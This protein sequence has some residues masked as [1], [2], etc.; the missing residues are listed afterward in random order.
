MQYHCTWHKVRGV[1]R[2]AFHGILSGSLGAP[3]LNYYPSVKSA[4]RKL[5][6]QRPSY[7]E[8]A[9]VLRTK[10]PAGDKILCFQI[11]KKAELRSIEFVT[12]L[13]FDV[14]RMSIRHKHQRSTK[15]E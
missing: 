5:F 2:E 1:H 7:C 4:D 13:H 12:S 15:G 10:K 9:V 14:S 11:F 8:C 6:N 3:N